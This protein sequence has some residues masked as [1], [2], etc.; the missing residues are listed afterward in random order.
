MEANNRH[1]EWMGTERR[2]E[3][4]WGRTRT[5]TGGERGWEN[6]GRK[7]EGMTEKQKGRQAN[8]R[9]RKERPSKMVVK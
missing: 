2:G 7:E 6:D 9:K 4:A 1:G 3:W 5:E 8:G